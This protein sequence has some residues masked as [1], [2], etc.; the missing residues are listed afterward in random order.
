MKVWPPKPGFTDMTS[1]KST[2]A[3]D[4]FERDDRRRRIEH[5]AGLDAE[6]LDRVN[7]AVQVGQHLDVHRDHR[8]A[9][10]GERLDVAVGVGDHQVH[11]ER[12]ACD[13]LRATA[14]PADRS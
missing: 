4:L 12:H 8:R 5:D 11:V 13:A 2:S 6:R 14:R 3:G 10:L 9:R 7:R 1:T